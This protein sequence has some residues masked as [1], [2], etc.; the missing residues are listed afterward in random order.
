MCGI[1]G[2]ATF[3]DDSAARYIEPML[4]SL[5]HRGPDDEGYLLAN[6]RDGRARQVAGLDTVAQLPYPPITDEQAGAWNLALGNRRLA[7]LDLTAA[8]HGPMS[9]DGERL[10]ITYNGE[11]Y[12][13]RELRHELQ[14][15]G[16]VF[17]SATDTEVIL[18]AYAQWGLDC[19]SRF[20]GMFAFALWDASRQRLFCARDRFGIKPLFYHHNPRAFL[21]ASEIKALLAHP[22][23]DVAPNDPIIYDY[24][25]LGVTDHTD[26]TFFRRIKR[27]PASHYL[28]LEPQNGNAVSKERWYELPANRAYHYAGRR[29]ESKPSAEFGELL[30]DAVRLRLRSDVAVGTCL[31]GGLDSSSIVAN[32]NRLLRDGGAVSR[33]AVGERQ[34]TF[35]ARYDDERIDEWPFAHQ[36]VEMTGVEAHCVYP[37]GK[38]GLWRELR[39]LVWHLEEP[40]GSTNMYAQWNVMRLARDNGVTVLLNGQGGDELL[41]GY[42]HYLGPYLAQTALQGG[43]LTAARA[44]LAMRA[45]T[46]HASPI[47]V[48]MG[49]YNL[50][51]S[52]LKRAAMALANARLRTHPGVS[53]GNMNP[54]FAARY[55]ERGAQFAKH[56]GYR[57]LADSLRADLT[58]FVLP[59]LLRYEDRISMAFSREARVPFLDVRLVEFAYALPASLRIRDG[60]TKWIVRDAMRGSLP[61]DV[62]WRR[63]KLGFP[64][65]Q[66]RWLQEGVEEIRKL[67]AAT[68]TR[69]RAYLSETMMTNL[70][71]I[72]PEDVNRV[73]G[74]WRMV[75]LEQWLQI[76]FS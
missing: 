34:R 65:P 10:W 47:L 53:P 56:P 30:Y 28:L 45:S 52:S 20:N 2:V 46:N 33:Q 38:N 54:S 18:A 48:G 41:A 63:D 58:A 29:S 73:P 23:V 4:S 9:Y 61:D 69:S 74:L 43:P 67:F 42:H 12:N 21:F 72:A 25:A 6:W 35:S 8:G 36:V 11:I 50:L 7:I 40:F 24:L 14:G 59:A 51:P 26:E 60:W 3:H 55:N 13:Y 66:R 27:L 16:H 57:N 37:Q 15:C 62:L 76:F 22:D 1:A 75:N 31:S 32:V 17:H 70:G 39:D 5:R 49:L 68:E 19:L 64:T 71:T 44:V